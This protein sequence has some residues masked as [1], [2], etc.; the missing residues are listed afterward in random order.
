MTMSILNTVIVASF[1]RLILNSKRRKSKKGREKKEDHGRSGGITM[2]DLNSDDESRRIQEYAK[3][4]ASV[5]NEESI[6]C[7]MIYE[8]VGEQLDKRRRK[9]DLFCY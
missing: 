3:P 2:F 9:E 7:V 8:H 4:Q 6:G 1:C 5:K